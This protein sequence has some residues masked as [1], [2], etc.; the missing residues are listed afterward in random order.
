MRF[1]RFSSVGGAS[2]DMILGALAD[3]GAD[4]GRVA[5]RLQAALP[6]PF[7]LTVEET[8]SHG[9]HGRRVTV[10]I[11]AAAHAHPAGHGHGAAHHHHRSWAEIRAWLERSPDWPEPARAL[12]IDVFTALAEA[13]GRVHGVPP[14]T[15]QFHEVGA[16]D[17]LV[18]IV[19]ACL[20]LHELD[21]SGVAVDEPLP[22]GRGT[23]RCAHGVYPVPPPA[24]VELLAGMAV[25]PTEV[26][27]EL[28]TPTGAALL[29][30]WRNKRPA[31]AA[32]RIVAAGHGFGYADLGNRPNVLRALLCETAGSPTGDEVCVLETQLDDASP[33]W[34]GALCARLMD[35]GALDVYTTGVQMKKQRPGVLLTVLARDADREALL[36]MVFRG[37]PTFGVRETRAT[38]TILPRRVETVETPYGPVRVKI[39]TWQGEDVTR[40]P[41]WE[42]CA[43]R[44]AERRVAARL[45]YEAAVRAAG[46]R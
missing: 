6:D 15:V 8:G 18:D 42:D 9:L 27:R 16:V 25:V 38:R 24:V 13:E 33:E 29:S 37:C 30:V 2:G 5:A 4:L 28:V 39:G 45:V 7:E 41:E 32:G 36:D 19:G 43:A 1:I 12:A 34:I 40:A 21:V 46:A 3:L 14:E 10:R 31:P 22:V 11:P 17:S 26:A 44:A 20:A 35:A 23:V